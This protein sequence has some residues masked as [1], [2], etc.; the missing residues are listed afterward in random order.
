M[1][2]GIAHLTSKFDITALKKQCINENRRINVTSMMYDR[3]YSF[4]SRSGML[5]LL[6]QK[7]NVHCEKFSMLFA[8]SITPLIFFCNIQASNDY[9]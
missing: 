7:I 5:T 4:A 8:I 6:A 3:N 1:L 2:I 9:F